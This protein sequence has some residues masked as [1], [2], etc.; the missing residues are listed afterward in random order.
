[1]TLSPQELSDSLR[2]NG[3]KNVEFI[4]QIPESVLDLRIYQDG[5]GW[6]VR[7]LLVHLV[8]AEKYLRILIERIAKGGEGVSED[9]DLDDYN[10]NAVR[11]AKEREFVWLADEFELLR[12]QTVEMVAQLTPQNLQ[13]KGRHPFLGMTQVSEMLKLMGLHVQLHL[14]DIRRLI[15]SQE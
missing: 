7:D 12:N 6:S 1:M 15:K 9:F 8:D 2:T 14:R 5:A 11:I 4:R 13:E 10:G 3:E